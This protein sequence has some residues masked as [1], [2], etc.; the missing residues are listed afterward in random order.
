MAK[1]ARAARDTPAAA[2]ALAQVVERDGSSVAA[3]REL[4]D[5]LEDSANQ[6]LLLKAHQRI[7]EVDPFDAASQV[8]LGRRALEAG[9]AEDAV[10]WLRAAVA[11]GPR[12]AVATHCDLADAYLRL[13]AR[14][15]AKIQT[16]QALELAPTYVRA[17]DL[18][19]TIVDAR[20]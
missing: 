2:R 1:L 16:L 12:D 20:P 3:A 8:A 6:K 7:A 11:A 13:G 4:V 14:A 10:R 17:Q 18:L 9:D 19:L 5:L 15:D